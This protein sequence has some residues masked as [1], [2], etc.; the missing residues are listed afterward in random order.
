MKLSLYEMVSD[1]LF[2]Y[3]YKYFRLFFLSLSS[4]LMFEKMQAVK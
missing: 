4:H 2:F 1:V 3:L